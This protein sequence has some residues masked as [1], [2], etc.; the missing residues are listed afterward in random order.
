MSAIPIFVRGVVVGKVSGANFI[1][2]VN[3]EKHFLKKPPAIC[4]DC[5][6]LEDA[7]KAGATRVAVK[8]QNEKWYIAFVELVELKGFKFNRNYGD[9]IA[10]H[11]WH[12]KPNVVEAEQHLE[13]VKKPKPKE[14]EPEKQILL[15][16]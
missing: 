5:K 4:F 12:F 9:Q 16:A 8:D 10:L 1:K 14:V 11:L 3:S 6:S 7:K 15:F 2:K 13:E